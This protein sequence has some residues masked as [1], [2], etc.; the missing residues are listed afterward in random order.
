MP[1]LSHLPKTGYKLMVLSKLKNKSLF[2]RGVVP[3]FF[4]LRIGERLGIPR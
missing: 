2:W 3:N 1:I 4:P